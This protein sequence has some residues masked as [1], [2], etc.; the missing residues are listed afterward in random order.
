[1][2]YQRRTKL[3][4]PKPFEFL[5]VHAD[6]SAWVCC[7]DW[8]DMPIGN[9]REDS[10]A[11]VWNSESAQDIRRSILDGSFRYCNL[12]TCP[13]LVQ[14]TLQRVESVS[15]LDHREL[16]DKHLVKLDRGPRSLSLTYDSTCNLKCPSCR[17]KIIRLTGER[18]K[19]AEQLQ[20]R[21]LHEGLAD[22]EEI[23]LTGYG[24]PFASDLYRRLLRSLDARELPKLSIHLMTNGLLLTPQMWESLHRIHPTIASLHVSIDAAT[25]ETYSINRGGRFD[26]L[27][28]NMAFVSR[29]VE[30]GKIPWLEISFVVQ[31]NNFREMKQFVELGRQFRASRVLFQ[32]L[33]QWGTYSPEDFRQRAIHNSDH[34]EHQAFLQE[35]QSPLFYDPIV[36]M[37]NLALMLRKADNTTS[38]V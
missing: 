27:L 7:H 28:R 21:I 34:P 4:C 24:D 2:S 26:T 36:D 16:I 8:L 13:A 33:I 9:L 15:R 11:E 12:E 38:H 17:V 20:V 32:Q 29:L 6:G 3:F 37:S 1:M 5:S 30:Q 22:A 14:G 35:L 18:K 19:E 31:C 10:V 25:A 23:L